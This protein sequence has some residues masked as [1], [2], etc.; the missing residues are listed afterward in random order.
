[1]KDLSESCL[2]CGKKEG[3][4]FN[5][6]IETTEGGKHVIVKICHQC[7]EVRPVSEQVEEVLSDKPVNWKN[8]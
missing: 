3:L 6:E 1:M 8:L 2:K 5:A 4:I 7:L